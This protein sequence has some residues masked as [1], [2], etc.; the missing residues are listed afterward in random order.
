[1][2][3]KLL[4]LSVFCY[5]CQ[6]WWCGYSELK[7]EGKLCDCSGEEIK[8][9]DYRAQ[10]KRCCSPPS[11][12][13]CEVTKEGNGKCKNSLV[14]SDPYQCGDTRL[15]GDKI[16]HCGEDVLTND[17]YWEDH[18]RCCTPPG[19]GHCEVTSEG[20]VKC[21]NSTAYSRD[22]QPCNGKCYYEEHQP[23]NGACTTAEL[24]QRSASNPLRTVSNP[25]RTDHSVSLPSKT[26]QT[27]SV[28]SMSDQTTQPSAKT[29][30][31][32]TNNASTL[33]RSTFC[34]FLIFLFFLSS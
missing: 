9:E 12:G 6:G 28:P 24:C 10:K 3:L 7:G 23:C 16:C 30:M 31:K 15:G 34:L 25:S 29:E 17:D 2:E 4:F 11:P 33:E 32:S 26:D 22:S 20:D 27:V 21:S 19:S 18:K 14:C 5:P 8:Q 1:M 13:H